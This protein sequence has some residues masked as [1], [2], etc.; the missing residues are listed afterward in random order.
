MEKAMSDTNPPKPNPWYME[1]RTR[2][3]EAVVLVRNGTNTTEIQIVVPDD[4]DNPENVVARKVGVIFQQPL[5]ALRM[6]RAIGLVVSD[7]EALVLHDSNED[8][9]N[10]YWA[11]VTQA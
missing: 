2:T 7:D 6:L 10:A 1:T 5:D 9:Y 11:S 3:G 8:D 4:Q